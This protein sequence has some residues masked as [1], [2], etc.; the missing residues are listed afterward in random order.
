MARRPSETSVLG[1]TASVQYHAATGGWFVR[2]G[3]VL[4]N[5]M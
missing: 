4:G 1:I 2:Q 3:K 5:L